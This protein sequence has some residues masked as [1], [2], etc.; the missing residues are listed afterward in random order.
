MRT[1]ELEFF[2][3]HGALVLMLK[4]KASGYAE[5]NAYA[6]AQLYLF[7]KANIEYTVDAAFLPTTVSVF[8]VMEDEN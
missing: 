5:A 4:I 7:H 1:F 8:E 2:S 6:Q 3:R